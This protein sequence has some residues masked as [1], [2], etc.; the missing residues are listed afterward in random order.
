MSEFERIWPEFPSGYDAW[1]T[2]DIDR[3]PYDGSNALDG[4][5]DDDD[6]DDE[7]PVGPNAGWA[8]QYDRDWD[9]DGDR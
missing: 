3:E 2:T 5:I 6:D 7:L 9:D 4:M 8:S 1:K